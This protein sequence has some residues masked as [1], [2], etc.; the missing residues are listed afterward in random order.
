MLDIYKGTNMVML[1]GQNYYA[2]TDTYTEKGK[3]DELTPDVIY[4]AD[5]FDWLGT[6]HGYNYATSNVN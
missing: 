3:H 4:D 2:A 6:G 1:D 5:K